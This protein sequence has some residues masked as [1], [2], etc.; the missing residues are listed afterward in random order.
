MY[1]HMR[2]RS[3]HRK[4]GFA[5]IEVLVTLFVIAMLIVGYAAAISSTSLTR[6]AKHQEIALRIASHE[7]ES[8][9]AIGYASTT[10]GAFND[11]L[12]SSLTNASGSVA[13]SSFNAQTKQVR[14]MVSWQEESRGDRIISLT[15]LLTQTGGL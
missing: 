11:S 1:E 5:F 15:T 14:V 3:L 9:R 4:R 6:E 2:V 7:L 13:V 12:M 8:V 10:S